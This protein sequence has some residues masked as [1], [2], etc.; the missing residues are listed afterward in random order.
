MMNDMAIF[1]CVPT[2]WVHFFCCADQHGDGGSCRSNG[3]ERRIRCPLDCRNGKYELKNLEF[4][5]HKS[6]MSTNG[7]A[8]SQNDAKQGAGILIRTIRAGS[9]VKPKKG[10]ICEVNSNC[11]HHCGL[12]QQNLTLAHQVH[13]EGFLEDGRQFDSSRDRDQPLQVKLG[14]GHVVEGWEV[15]LRHMEIGQIAEVTIPHLYGYGELGY[16]PKIPPRSTLI[17]RL[18][19][20]RVKPRG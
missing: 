15:A 10:D 17:Y 3:F 4:P 7:A 8:P 16:P 20:L 9:G 19:I 2:Q 6:S 18:E 12:W 11:D 5:L 13:Y 14:E 1:H